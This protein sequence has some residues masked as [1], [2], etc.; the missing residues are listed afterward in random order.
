VEQFAREG[1]RV[2]ATDV[3]VEEGEALV[4]ELGPAV[5]FRQHD[6]TSEAA[7]RELAAELESDPVDILVNNAGA[8]VH[9]IPL[10]EYEPSEWTRIVD[11]NLTSV[12]LGMR[13]L[14]P[15]MLER[16]HGSI[17][18]MSSIAGVVGIDVAPAYAAAKAGVHILTKCAALSYADK[19]I[20]VN[21]VHPGLIDTP[22]VAEQPEWATSGFLAATPMGRMG[23]P[24]EVAQAAA[25]LAS[26]EASFVT[27]AE[28][29]VDG[30]F[31]AK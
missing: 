11:I 29:Y 31:L 18:N 2:L 15:M 12:F 24:S 27:G 8:V 7:W 5:R 19:G 6:V 25:F 10:H 17:V 13:F 9:F 4:E 22:M 14:I 1:A 20:R 16:G 23:K 21:S 28:L 30:A 26:S 3:R